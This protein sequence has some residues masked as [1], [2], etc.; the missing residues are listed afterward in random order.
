MMILSETAI[1]EFQAMFKQETGRDITRAEA[2]EYAE[3][4]LRLV[5]TLVEM[6]PGEPP[7]TE[8]PL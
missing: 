1:A 6:E 3:R 7:P 5:R 2:A 4:L 8:Q